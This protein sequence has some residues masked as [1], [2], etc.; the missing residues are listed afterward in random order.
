MSQQSPRPRPKN[1]FVDWKKREALAE[2]MI[3]LIGQMYRRNN[4]HSHIYG[5]PLIN[6]SVLDIMQAHRF[7]RSVEGNELSEFETFP[8]LQALA[9]I[10]DLGSAEIDVGHITILY[11]QQGK[12]ANLSVADFV[13]SQLAELIGGSHKPIDQPRDVVLYG[14]GR[15][16]RLVARLLIEKTAGGDTLRL[17]AI[18][19]RKGRGD[20]NDL[21][22]R[23]SLMRRDSV[24]G[25][26]QGTIR[27]DE[28]H[29]SFV[30]NGNEVRVIYADQPCDVDYASYDI[31][32]AIIVDNTGKWRS[33]EALGQHLQ[34]SGVAKVLLTAPAKGGIKNIVHGVNQQLIDPDDRL[35][36]ASSC[37]TNAVAL[38]LYAVHTRFGIESGHIETVHAYTNDQHLIDNYH[39]SP[40]RG[41]SAA[42]NLVLTDTGAAKAVGDVL[43]ELA[44]KLSGHAIR[45]PVPNVSLA[46]LKLRL[47]DRVDIDQLNEHM[48][49][50]A[51]H[52]P[53]RRQI[54]Y[55]NSTEIVSSDII[56]SRE[57]CVLDS[58]ATIANGRDCVMYGW[59]DNE[60]GYACQVY[61]LLEELAGVRYPVYPS[62]D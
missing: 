21:A 24:H 33:Q 30:A 9:S 26:F 11:E 2:A 53:L 12:P 25:G 56:G 36:A 41:R 46:V 47:R 42:M 14:F 27:V 4:I 3:P 28:E 20:D 22:K 49:Q 35:V 58:V 5:Q 51:L 40:R 7:V 16:G 18:V 38:L 19:A 50:V 1:Y 52:S 23:A 60:F 59:Y 62:N 55:T 44:G 61:R 37:T 6:Q 45:V 15:I 48:R 43:P 10:S 32:D 13:R 8:V 57:A 54:G 29:Q 34:A 17:R 39:P 31:D